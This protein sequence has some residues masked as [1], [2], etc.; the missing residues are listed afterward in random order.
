MVHTSV[1]CVVDDEAALTTVIAALANPH[2]RRAI[3]LLALQP[4]TTQ[5]VAAHIGLSLTAIDRH[6]TILETA[7][8]IQRRKRGRVNF[9]ALRRP[10]LRLLD[11]WLS[12]FDP[13]WGSDGDSLD[14]YLAALERSQQPTVYIEEN[15]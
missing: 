12:G 10:G 5:Q 15:R 13:Q 4:A 9:L 7:G 3:E 2:R 11:Q 1:K 8:L 6:L 14:N